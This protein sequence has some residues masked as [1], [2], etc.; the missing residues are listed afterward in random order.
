MNGIKLTSVILLGILAA[1]KED[2]QRPLS[3]LMNGLTLNLPKDMLD[4]TVILPCDDDFITTL[5][6]RMCQLNPFAT[7]AH[8]SD[9]YYVN[10]SL[11]SCSHFFFF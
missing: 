9:K 5:R 10:F 1:V 8:C 11:K 6:N 3:E 7:S 4:I 2:L